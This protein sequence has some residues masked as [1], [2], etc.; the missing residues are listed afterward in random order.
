M[1]AIVEQL[2]IEDRNHLRS[3][4]GLPLLD[5]AIE[6]TRL[7][8]VQADADFEAAFAAR[9]NEFAHQWTDYN[10][11]SSIMSKLARYHHAR[12]TVRRDLLRK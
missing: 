11:A 12:Q 3:Q 1:V 9:R 8:A 2:D 10:N 6:I 7:A 5:P 4:A